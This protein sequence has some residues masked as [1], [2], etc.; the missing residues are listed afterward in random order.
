MYLHLDVSICP[1]LILASKMCPKAC[2]YK[3][4]EFYCVTA[5]EK[6]MRLI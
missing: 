5:I 3:G 6:R 1:E 4:F 2:V